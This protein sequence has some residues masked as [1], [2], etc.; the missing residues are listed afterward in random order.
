MP[1]TIKDHNSYTFAEL[2]EEF[3][4]KGGNNPKMPPEFFIEQA[5]RVLIGMGWK[6][7]KIEVLDG[8]IPQVTMIH[9]PT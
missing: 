8:D 1:K 7:T 5:Q 3:G 6:F 4:I 9:P 2:L